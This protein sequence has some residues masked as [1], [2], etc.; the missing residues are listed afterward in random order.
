MRKTHDISQNVDSGAP[1]LN[2]PLL[3]AGRSNDFNEANHSCKIG[4]VDG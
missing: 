1:R 4:E 3:R 2:F